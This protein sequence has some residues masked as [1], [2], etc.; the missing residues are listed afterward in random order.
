MHF[1]KQFQSSQAGSLPHNLRQS[2]DKYAVLLIELFLPH[3]L[4]GRST[5]SSSTA[6]LKMQARAS[7]PALA[8]KFAFPQ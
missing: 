1:R 3:W 4:A 7:S 8:G 2:I 5:H 6:N